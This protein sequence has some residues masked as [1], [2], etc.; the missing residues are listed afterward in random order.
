MKEELGK[1]IEEVLKQVKD[2]CQS[3]Q[4]GECPYQGIF[5]CDPAGGDAS[6]P[7]DWAV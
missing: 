2:Y 5:G 7:G 1:V 3:H 4:C 6:I